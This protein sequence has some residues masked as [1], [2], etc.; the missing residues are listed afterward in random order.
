MFF[1]DFPTSGVNSTISYQTY[2][3]TDISFDEWIVTGGTKAF[4]GVTGELIQS[5]SIGSNYVLSL[6]YA[7]G[8]KPVC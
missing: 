1:P 5:A 7:N 3:A 4:K 8:F 2:G 6:S